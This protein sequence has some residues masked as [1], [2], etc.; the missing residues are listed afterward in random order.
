MTADMTAVE[1]VGLRKAFGPVEVLKGVDLAVPAGTVFALL[2][3][4]GAGKTTMVSILT[5]L[6]RPDGG[7]AAVAGFDVAREPARVREAITVTGQNV[8]VDP[9]LTGLENLALIARL[10][11]VPQAKR[12]AAGLVEQF[13]LAEAASKPAGTYSGGM[14]RR[15]D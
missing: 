13:G 15:L 1:A 5:T 4:N 2:G 11:H 10:R 8:T 7:R 9:V 6:L 14:K 12:V 3:A